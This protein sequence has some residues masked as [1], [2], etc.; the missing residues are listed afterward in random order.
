MANILQIKD[1]P[2]SPGTSLEPTDVFNPL[3]ED[4]T[5]TWDGNPYTIP[6]KSKK[7]FPEF[8]ARHLAKHLARKIVYTIAYKEIEELGKGQLTPDTAKAIPGKRVEDMEA[9]LL[10]PVGF[11]PEEAK[12]SEGKT[13]ADSDPKL[14]LKQKRIEALEKARAAK[15]AKKVA[16]K[17]AQKATI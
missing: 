14:I 8:L 13:P 5:W 15:A 10:N 11:S 9:W 3:S 4:F 6:A 2:K 1:V 12:V 7:S 16:E 17:A